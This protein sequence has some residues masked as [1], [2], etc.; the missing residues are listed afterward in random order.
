MA[1]ADPRAG[2]DPWGLQTDVTKC[3]A[4]QILSSPWHSA[5]PCLPVAYR[6]L[7]VF[8][9]SRLTSSRAEYRFRVFEPAAAHAAHFGHRIGGNFALVVSA[10][11]P[12]S[13]SLGTQRS[14]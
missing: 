4:P 8:V 9:S 2:G 7:R 14:G 6:L 5:L 3:D 1:S 11:A 10:Q 13:R 12:P